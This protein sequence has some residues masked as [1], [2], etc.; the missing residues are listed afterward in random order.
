MATCTE[1]M[2]LQ[3]QILQKIY[4]NAQ[5]VTTDAATKSEI[6][7]LIEDMLTILNSCCGGVIGDAG[8]TYLSVD[9]TGTSAIL[10]PG[11]SGY[12]I[13]VVQVNISTTATT[14]LTWYS[15]GAVDTVISGPH[16]IDT[17]PLELQPSAWG[18]FRTEAGED[19]K[20]GISGGDVGGII[21]Y[22][23]VAADVP[24]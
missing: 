19:L 5:P 20:I 21:G 18:W 3:R 23:L 10:V 24:T 11:V 14:T 17:E 12:Q 6:D 2:E 8:V 22:V 13:V 15:G 4:Y 9:E 16:Q 1:V 7:D